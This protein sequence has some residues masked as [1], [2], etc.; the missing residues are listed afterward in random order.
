MVLH[1]ELDLA[2][3]KVR[4]KTGGGNA[5]HNGL[6]SID[7][8][9]GPD[10][11]RVRIG[12]GHPGEKRLVHGHVLHDFAKSDQDWLDRLLPALAEAAPYLIRGDDSGFMNKVGLLINPNPPSPRPPPS[13]PSGPDDGL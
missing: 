12:V 10:Y 5:G 2:P 13:S 1:D 6:R 7:R 9:V 8:H 3:G 4:V 11:K